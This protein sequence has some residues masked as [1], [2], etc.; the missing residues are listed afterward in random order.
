MSVLPYE[1]IVQILNY[2][3]EYLFQIL[4]HEFI[5]NTHNIMK[6][7]LRFQQKYH[8]VIFLKNH[9][10]D[11]LHIA[12]CNKITTAEKIMF[13][14]EDNTE[15]CYE[16]NDCNEIDFNYYI[17]PKIGL[18]WT[19][20]LTSDP[21]IYGGRP[22]AVYTQTAGSNIGDERY[23]CGICSTQNCKVFKWNDFIESN[24][25]GDHAIKI[26]ELIDAVVKKYECISH[27]PT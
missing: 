19:T 27:L 1:L 23:V 17:T 12:T 2:I 21:C 11:L 15:L 18:K 9:D 3:P 8:L 22:M 25:Y 14:L 4:P 10:M 26:I 13:A 24:T 16:F 20:Q 6:K 5:R 7:S